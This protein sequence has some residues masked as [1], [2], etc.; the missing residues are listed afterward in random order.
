MD[1]EIRSKKENGG[2]K[3]SRERAEYFRL[4]QL[5]YSNR[6]ASEL[7]GINPRTGRE[8]RNGRPGGGRKRPRPPA[9]IVPAASGPSRY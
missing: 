1:F 8:W 3:L 6:E 7:V 5:G 9:H 4:V 2:R